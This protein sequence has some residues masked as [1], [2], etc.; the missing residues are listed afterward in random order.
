MESVPQFEGSTRT[1]IFVIQSFTAGKYW[2][3]QPDVFVPNIEQTDLEPVAAYEGGQ[4]VG[5][6][7][8]GL[9]VQQHEQSIKPLGSKGVTLRMQ[10][11]QDRFFPPCT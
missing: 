9:L 3:L 4:L 2:L 6:S 8:N 5:I 10:M 1:V 11:Q 7:G